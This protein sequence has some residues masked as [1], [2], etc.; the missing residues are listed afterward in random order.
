MAA[1]ISGLAASATTDTTSASNIVS[2]TMAVARLPLMGA[3]GA[4]HAAGLVP[5]GGVTS[6]TA[7]VLHEDGTWG[8]VTE[9]QVTSLVADLPRTIETTKGDLL[10]YGAAPARLALER[11]ARC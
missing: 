6:G 1:N 10:G 5:D 2:G 3:S 9:A 11:M 7:K 4:A 8:N